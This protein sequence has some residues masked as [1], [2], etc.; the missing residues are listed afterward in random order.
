VEPERWRQIERLFESA[1]ERPESDHAA[2]LERACAGDDE[3]RREVASLLAHQDVAADFI[4][5]PAMKVGAAFASHDQEPATQTIDDAADIIGHTFSHYRVVN[6]LGGGGMGVVY[7]AEDVRLDRPVALKFLPERFRRDRAALERF[8]REARAASSLNHPNICT[9]FD[10]GEQDGRPFIVMERLEGQTL[11]HHIQG[12]PLPMEDVLRLGREILSVLE[13]AHAKGI[14][15]RDIKPANI[16]ITDRGQA[17]VLDFGVAKLVADLESLEVTSASTAPAIGEHTLTQPGVALGTL[18]YMSPEQAHGQQVDARS[19]LFSFGAVLYEMATGTRAFPNALDWTQPTAAGLPSAL[20]AIVF[21]LLE[22]DVDLRYQSAPDVVVDIERIQ[23]AEGSRDM[24]RQRLLVALAGL[25]MATV[26]G[27]TLWFRPEPEQARD[28]WV[29]LTNFPDSV[30]QPAVSPDGRMLAFIRGPQTFMTSGQIYVKALP[31]GEPVQL[32]RDKPSKM[33]P[34]FSPDGLR[35]AYT[36]SPGVGWGDTWVVPVIS[37]Q[38]RRFLTN[39]TG[40]AWLGGNRVLFSEVK[41]HDIH[42]ALVASGENRAGARDVYVPATN[43]GMAHRSYVSPDGRSVLLVE[44]ERGTFL[45]C[46]LIPMDGRSAGRQVG[47]PGA[48]CTFAGW[49]PDG[50][51][52]FLNSSAGGMFH[53]WRQRF[54]DGQPEQITSGVSEEEGIAITP[55]G[56]SLITAVGQRQSIVS[57]RNA[58]DERQI[59]LEGLSYDPKFAPD[60]KALYYRVSK[61]TFDVRGS[62]Q[63]RVADPQ[64]GRS[65]PL[66]PG[67]EIVG[68]P[69]GRGYDISHDGRW[70]VASTIDRDGRSRLWLA[71]L[72]G[73]SPPQ[74]IA[75]AEGDSPAFG[76]TGEIYYRSVEGDSAF[77]YRIEQSGLNRRK[78]SERVIADL[79]GISPDGNWLVVRVVGNGQGMVTAISLGDDRSM[80]IFEFQQTRFSWTEDEIHI[81]FPEHSL[82]NDAL[83]GK[84]YVIPLAEGQAF[85]PIPAGGFRS[86]AEIAKLVGVTVIDAYDVTAGPMPNVY[87]YSRQSVQR[88]LYRITLP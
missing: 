8:R 10:I 78:V 31:D 48:P 55:D 83:A 86:E 5:V 23:R 44:M 65:E 85:P 64:S 36:V 3:L 35:I 87:A 84:T 30:A 82:G 41:D 80:P 11:K 66:L 73:Q 47:P 27:G 79:N 14:V 77:V 67:L 81:S 15:H 17:K 2:F 18:R 76:P 69:P 60:G 4:E 46:R 13:A 22:R 25:V 49:S 57:V 58:A 33:S 40:L 37:G 21:K 74:P 72:D 59:S 56:T 26:V 63:L 24:R 12:K 45:P 16:F 28:S 52:M 68:R 29:Q 42:M 19:D 32:T 34:A 88:N 38:P 20:Q 53:I 71:E 54:P 7:T 61:G 50:R 75:N 1:L 70:V 43:R 62:S 6:R 51:W 9:V 39:A